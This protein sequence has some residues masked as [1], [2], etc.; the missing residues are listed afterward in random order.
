MKTPQTLLRLLLPAA[1]ALLFG[2]AGASG[3][4]TTAPATSSQPTDSPSTRVATTPTPP[5]TPVPGAVEVEQLL[6]VSETEPP[7]Q[8]QLSQLVH[9]RAGWQLRRLEPAP[10]AVELQRPAP[11]TVVVSVGQGMD[12]ALQQAAE[13]GV[14]VVAVE[15]PG[16]EPGP[17]LSTVGETRY[18]QAGFLAGVMAGLASRTLW[19]GAVGGT[20][21]LQEAA[22]RE[23]FGQGLLLECPRCRLV[24]LSAAEMSVGGFRGQGVD[25]VFVV[26]GPQAASAAK[27]L[28]AAGLPMVWVGEPPSGG[29]QWAGRV[30]VDPSQAVLAALDQLLATGEG[31]AW[32]SSIE[33]RAISYTD[34]DPALISPGRQRLLDEAL[35]AVAS[36]ELDIGT[37]G[38]P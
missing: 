24:E 37:G 32:V 16:L 8:A 4:A 29:D 36:G 19:V 21:G 27:T 9:D 38:Q 13:S 35:Q 3:P 23:G 1:A 18:D 7:W 33:N 14:P 11:R 28:A 10:A 22:Y 12:G 20:G 6:L 17:W 34:L 25:V 15:V 5:G 2:C 26:P 30:T 31:Q